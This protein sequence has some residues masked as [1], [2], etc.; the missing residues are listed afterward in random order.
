MS[1]QT[2]RDLRNGRRHRET[3]SGEEKRQKGHVCGRRS[4]STKGGLADLL[5]PRTSAKAGCLQDQL[6]STDLN[7]SACQSGF[8]PAAI[9]L[10]KIKC[11]GFRVI[12]VTALT[13]LLPFEEI[14]NDGELPTRRENKF[15]NLGALNASLGILDPIFPDQ[16]I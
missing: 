13:I 4:L 10:N 8:C 12:V 14:P 5:T 15:L 16:R 9:S 1:L 7:Q 2:S 3:N 11:A 6:V